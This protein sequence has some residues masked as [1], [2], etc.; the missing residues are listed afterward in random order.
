MQSCPSAGSEAKKNPNHVLVIYWVLLNLE[1]K[2]IPKAGN[3]PET[4]TIWEKPSCASVTLFQA[5]LIYVPGSLTHY[6][7]EICFQMPLGVCHSRLVTFAHFRRQTCPHIFKLPE[8]CSPRKV[9][10]SLADSTNHLMRFI[11]SWTAA[12]LQ[13]R[14]LAH[15]VSSRRFAESEIKMPHAA[16]KGWLPCLL[17][18]PFS[19]GFPKETR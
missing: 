8:R 6:Q 17:P 4:I 18:N 2:Q 1:R 16:R 15:G 14:T 5:I 13:P 9:L 19:P 12:G 11:C 3:D 7:M 10:G